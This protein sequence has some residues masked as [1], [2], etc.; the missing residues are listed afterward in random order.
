[1]SKCIRLFFILFCFSFVNNVFAADLAAKEDATPPSAEGALTV[2]QI[3]PLSNTNEG[4]S[5][6]K[7]AEQETSDVDKAN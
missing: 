7:Q 3:P 6:S 2:D 4:P 5:A 1:M